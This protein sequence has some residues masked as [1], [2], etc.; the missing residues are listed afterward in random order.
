M[1][2]IN[3]SPNTWLSTGEALA[4]LGVRPQTL[5]ASVSRKRIRA[6]LDPDDP[7]RSLYHAGDV[8]HLAARGR[9]RPGK[10]RVATESVSWGIP[11]LASGISTVAHVRL[12]YRGEDAMQLA[13]RE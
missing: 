9:G 6:K 11:V 5:Y 7:R 12:W 3:M 1:N 2:M 4:L 13:E 10:E 8:R